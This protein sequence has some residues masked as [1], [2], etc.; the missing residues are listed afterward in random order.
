MVC[1]A[2]AL[3]VGMDL[4]FNTIVS[5]ATIPIRC[6]SKKWKQKRLQT[7]LISESEKTNKVLYDHDKK[8]LR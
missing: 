5:I 4:V 8:I 2:N 3:G 7:F 1:T 6:A